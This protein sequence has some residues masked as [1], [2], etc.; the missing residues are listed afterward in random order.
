MNKS[1]VRDKTQLFTVN[2]SFFSSF[3]KHSVCVFSQAANPIHHVLWPLS[4]LSE[5]YHYCFAVFFYVC[6]LSVLC[7]V[8]KQIIKGC[9]QVGE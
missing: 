6:I 9:L 8:L 5:S 7:S 4:C 3:S 1:D 2:G